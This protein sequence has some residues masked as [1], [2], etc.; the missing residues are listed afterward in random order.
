MFDFLAGYVMGERAASRAASMSRAAAGPAGSVAGEISDVNTRINRL[1]LVVEALW[2]L[3]KQQGW[4]DE[5]LIAKIQ[6]LD[7]ADGVVDGAHTPRPVKCAKC[8]SMVEAGRKSC[9]FCG[10]PVPGVGPTAGI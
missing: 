6:E 2:E 3:L 1:L 5:H 10:E 4:T 9:A 8:D 7:E